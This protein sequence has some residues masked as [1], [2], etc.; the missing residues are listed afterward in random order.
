MI[1]KAETLRILTVA[2]LAAL[3]SG[4]H[5]AGAAGDEP[6]STIVL[7]GGKEGTAFRKM[8][9]EG[10]DRFRLDFERPSLRIDLDPASAPGLDWDNT[11][12][13]IAEG[14]IDL[15][16]PLVMLSAAE[17]SPYLP[18]PWLDEYRSGDI[19][20]F[21]PALKGVERWK[22]TIADPRNGEVISFDGKGDPPDVIGW[23]GLSMHGEPMP[24][25]YTYSYVVE[26][27]DRAGN[28]RNFVGKGFALP[29]YRVETE[30][31]AYFLFPG[32][33]LGRRTDR[34][35]RDAA[36]PCPAVLEAASRM[37][38]REDGNWKIVITVTA[39]TYDQADGMARVLSSDLGYLLLGDPARVQQV[40]DVSADA[41]EGGTVAIV[42]KPA[43]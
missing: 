43:G 30:E 19:I 15:S 35:G 21:R 13:V 40:V 31:S 8:T 10:E 9:I 27:R 17:G 42:M 33:A 20:R 23:D 29:P 4:S 26:A 34:H 7:E 11:W 5:P 24:P 36:I 37:N 2:V 16:T 28:S 6:D 38:Q 22:L 25:G 1:M 32:D 18:R 39:R 12:D 14:A 3:L 41:P